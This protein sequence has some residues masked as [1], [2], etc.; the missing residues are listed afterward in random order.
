MRLA[1][2]FVNSAGAAISPPNTAVGGPRSG[3]RCVCLRVIQVGASRR[4]GKPAAVSC[5]LAPAWPPH[6]A[7]NF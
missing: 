5:A 1:R 7:G 4:I 6:G 2:T 3:Q